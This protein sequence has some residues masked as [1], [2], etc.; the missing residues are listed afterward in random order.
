MPEINPL[1]DHRRL[2]EAHL[3]AAEKLLPERDL[4]HVCRALA[5]TLAA[6]DALHKQLRELGP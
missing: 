6:L 5:A 2:A 3:A 1:E 4:W